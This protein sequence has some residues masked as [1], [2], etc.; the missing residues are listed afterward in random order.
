[1]VSFAWHSTG[2]GQ[3]KEEVIG[4]ES[5]HAARISKKHG[6]LQFLEI[7]DH[8]ALYARKEENSYITC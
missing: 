2:P 7:T 4:I 6:G 8:S 5:E 1:L 3:I